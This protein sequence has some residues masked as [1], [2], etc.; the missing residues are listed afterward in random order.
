MYI[1]IGFI[2]TVLLA[3]PVKFDLST[4]ILLSLVL[5][6]TMLV[7]GRLRIPSVYKSAG[8]NQIL[9]PRTLILDDAGFQ[10]D[11]KN[12]VTT[13]VPWGVIDKI[14]WSK[15]FLALHSPF[16]P[17]LVPRGVLNAEATSFIER[18]TSTKG[19]PLT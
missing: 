3:L 19:S 4:A 17:V 13:R 10:I 18:C 5:C 14:A 11:Y 7:T 12:G 15:D 6:A 16:G 9:I 2:V 1:C 8:R